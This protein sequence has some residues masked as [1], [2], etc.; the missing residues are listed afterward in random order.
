MENM[1]IEE[2]LKYYSVGLIAVVRG[3]KLIELREEDT[4][5]DD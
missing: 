2:V 4:E 1:T 3:G 5:D